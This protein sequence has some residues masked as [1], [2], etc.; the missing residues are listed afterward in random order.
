M[1]CLMKYE[2][3][4]LGLGLF[5]CGGLRVHD[6]L[7]VSVCQQTTSSSR[8]SNDLACLSFVHANAPLIRLHSDLCKNAL[9]HNAS[10]FDEM[11]LA[12]LIWALDEMFKV[13]PQKNLFLH[14]ACLTRAYYKH[15][16]VVINGVKLGKYVILFN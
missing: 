8:T 13:H 9:S 4:S 14:A 6:R 12:V 11:L 15:V 7:H 5:V 3:N 2:G 1:G 16:A 10:T